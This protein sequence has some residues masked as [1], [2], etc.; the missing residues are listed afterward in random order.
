MEH[1]VWRSCE[2]S[3]DITNTQS[4]T[5]VRSLIVNPHTS[6]STISLILEALTRSLNLTTHSL[7]RQRTLKLLTDV[8]SRRPYLSSLIFQ[9]I[10]SITLDFESLA[11]LCSISEL[12]KNLKVELVDRLFIS[13]CFDAPACE[14]LRLLR[15]GERLGVGVHVLL[16]VFL[17]FS[18]DP[19][20]YVRKEALNG[21]VSLCKYGVFEDKSVIEGCYRR[22][23]E[24]LKDADDCVRSAAVNLV[25]EW[26]LMLIAANQEEDKTDWF[27]TVFLQLCSM[28]RDMSMGVRVGAFSALG[29]IQIVS[30][31]ILLQTLSKKVLPIIKEKKSQIAE[32]FQSLAASAAGAFMH[33][34][35]DEFYE[36]RKS[37]CY[38]LRKLV[39]LSAEFA[40]RALNLLIDLLNDS[41]LVV[42]L[43][44]LGTLHHMAASD[45][46][47]VQ[48]MHMHMFLGT[49][50]DNNDIIRT[51]ARKV[52]KYV[53]LPSMELFRLSIDGLLGNLDIYPQD[54]AD[55]FSVLFY[56]GRSHKDFTTSI[57]KE[58]YQEIEPVSN[59]NMSLDSARVAAFLVLAISAPFSHDQNGQSIPPRYFSYAVTLLGRISFALR[60]ILDQS[61]L[62]A[63]IS[64][65]SR[66]PISSGMEVEG[67]ESSLPVGTSNIECQ[68]KEHDQFRKF[69]DLIFAKVKDVWVLVHSSC[70]SAALKTLRACKEE[71]TMLSLAL[72]EPTG[73]VAF[74]SQ[75]LKV[76]KLLAKIW[77]NIV[78]KVQ[79]YEIGELEILLSKLERRLREM[80]SRFI[81]FSKEEESYVLELILVACILRL[82]KAEICCYHTTLKRLSATISLIEFLH[83]EGSIELSNFVV[84]VKKTLHESGISIGGTLCSPFG[85][86]KLIDHFSIKQFSSCTGVRHLYAAM[87]VPNIDS[88]N[89]LPFVPGL[90]VAIPLTITLHNVLS[91]TRLWLRLAM[92]EESIQFLFLD[93]NILGG[94]DE[95]KKCTFVAPFYR[96]PKTGSFTLRVCIGMECMFEDVHSVKNFGGPKRRLVYLCPEKEVYLSMV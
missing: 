40:G 10:H 19:Y 43:E 90:P 7:T 80:R 26:G 27:D 62:L 96:T 83:E 41:S 31:D 55:V 58:A 6:N 33:G 94:S 54:E 22:G 84:E 9:S 16:T 67:E 42:R 89:P 91:E 69:M 65:C 68:L 1:H 4:L 39:I 29:K 77:G 21:L 17:G 59:G 60:D 18:K 51:A 88:E 93:L 63:Y 48:E 2:G 37:A 45:C 49:L 70:I 35:E 73:V 46:L 38:S 95:V 11:A 79:S 50:I 71:L 86:M 24:L 23:V 32:R 20:P 12:N 14:R 56:M 85:F 13:M 76:T 61:T 34:L 64:R 44:A 53:K 57:I 30:E 72:A 87:N 25:S 15:N 74:M 75:Y 28:V 66:A 92:S 5:S 82:S 52:Y 36:V 78:W 47:N 8:A 81:G 3:L